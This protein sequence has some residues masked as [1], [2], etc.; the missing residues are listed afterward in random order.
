MKMVKSLLLGTAA[1]FVAVAGAQAADMPV[2]GAAVQY[3][4]ICS[5]YGDGFYY[6]PGTD[7]CV[8]VGG[9][10]RMQTSWAPSGGQTN[11]SIFGG[12]LANVSNT[13]TDGNGD[14]S[15]RARAY[16]SMDTRQQTEYGVLR[17][18]INIGLSGDSPA[19]AVFSGNRA[20]VQFAGF[21]VGLAQSF[22]DFYSS[23]AT[24]FFGP[25][26]SDTGDGGWRVAAY[27][28]NWGNGITSTLSLEESRRL[29]VVNTNWASDPFL[30]ATAPLNSSAVFTGI[31]TRKVNFPDIVSALRIDQAWGGGQIMFAAHDASPGYYAGPIQSNANP[32]NV[33][34]TGTTLANVTGCPFGTVTGAEVC[35]HPADK[36]GWAAG[37]GGRLNNITPTGSYFQFQ[38]NYTKGA[39]RYL[40]V[41][42][43]GAGSG[44]FF[45][46][47]TLGYGW[48]T[49]GVYSNLTGDVRLTTAYGFNA[50]YD[51]YWT[52]ALKTSVYS[53]AGW[54]VYDSAANNAICT[55][56]SQFNT[57]GSLGGPQPGV[58]A[59]LQ[60]GGQYPGFTNCNNNWKYWVL[61][62]RTQWN[63]TPA[64]YVGLDVLYTKLLTASSGFV[65]YTAAAGNA[66]PTGYYQ[67]TDQDAWIAQVRFHRDILP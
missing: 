9:Y 59:G 42:P 24:S 8:K 47:A 58:G 31:E 30:V 12:N 45:K 62:S 28:Q 54:V 2:K 61:G 50:A 20:F 39:M 15:I 22:Y 29:T 4:K 57:A 36:I 32:L 46:G 48:A 37:V 53:A 18:Y 66:K 26:S 25:P 60:I 1:G 19:G 7:I 3:V 14:W 35:G 11:W 67:L 13:R 49:D 38:V 64:F 5:L 17:T 63:I 40:A 65:Y 23:P 41:T 34:P 6:L 16:I 21:T 43:F 56:E 52:K 10:V 51:H 27:T 55:L 33:A 44:A